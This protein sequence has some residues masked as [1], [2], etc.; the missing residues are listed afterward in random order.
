M[1]KT[2][3]YAVEVKVVKKLIQQPCIVIISGVL[4]NLV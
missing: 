2:L 4:K 3:F 1:S